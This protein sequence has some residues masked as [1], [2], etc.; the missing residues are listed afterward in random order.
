MRESGNKRN[1]PIVEDVDKNLF[2]H[3]EPKFA[4]IGERK[5]S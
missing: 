1:D 5:G 4:S 2:D 3:L